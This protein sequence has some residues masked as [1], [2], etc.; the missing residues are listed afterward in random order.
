VDDTAIAR[1]CSLV[2]LLLILRL[3]A[4]SRTYADDPVAIFARSATRSLFPTG[5]LL[6]MNRMH[7]QNPLR[8]PGAW[9]A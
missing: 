2:A 4:P 5:E 6:A 3:V 9:Q 8:F 1:E 7:S